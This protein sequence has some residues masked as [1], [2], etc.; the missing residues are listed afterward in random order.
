MIAEARL[1]DGTLAQI[2]PLYPEDRAAL[3]DGYEQLSTDARYHR[4]LASVPHLSDALLDHLVD[5]VD[6]VD[7]VALALVVIDEDHQGVPVGVARI[8]RY[9]EDP[10]AADVAVT[11]LDEWQGRGVATALLD[12][13]MRQRPPGVTELVTTVT[14]DN[15]A[16]LAMLRR[17][18]PTTTTPAGINRLD[19]VVDLGHLGPAIPSPTNPTLTPTG[20]EN[21][22]VRDHH[23]S[24][25]RTVA[26]SGD[27]GPPD[28]ARPDRCD[29][30]LGGV[31]LPGR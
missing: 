22:D 3:R 26:R 21:R 19:V 4:F 5:E 2:W 23:H 28:A 1:A 18:G 12:E 7:H 13:L 24:P 29:P 17:L 30:E 25:A 31:P 16:S 27:V 14:A 15:E 20:L 8:I 11:V 10:T 6:G 9:R